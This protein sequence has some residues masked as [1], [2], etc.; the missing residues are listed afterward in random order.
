MRR[1]G[2]SYRAWQPVDLKLIEG[3]YVLRSV[4]RDAKGEL[5][6]I[7][8]TTY[9]HPRVYITRH[10]VYLPVAASDKAAQ[11]IFRNLPGCMGACTPVRE[12]PVY[13]IPEKPKLRG[14]FLYKW[15]SMRA[16][17]AWGDTGFALAG[18]R[19]QREAQACARRVIRGF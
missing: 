15:R 6:C 14:L 10:G 1:L 12:R 9:Y 16:V 5:T 18:P 3:L 11:E 8:W 7:K 17:C 19:T 2:Y 4:V 13:F